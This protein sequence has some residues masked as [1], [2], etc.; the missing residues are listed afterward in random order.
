MAQIT[1]TLSEELLTKI[2]QRATQLGTTPEELLSR[3][4]EELFERSTDDAFRRAATHVL[5]KNAELY[6][7]LA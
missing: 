2:R 1:I 6:R 7:R 5:E 4:T 3:R